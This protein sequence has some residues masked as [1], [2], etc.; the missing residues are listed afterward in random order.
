VT[1]IAEDK[2]YTPDDMAV[3]AQ[4]LTDQYLHKRYPKAPR[5]YVI[6]T[7]DK[8]IATAL[9]E[10]KEREEKG[11]STETTGGQDTSTAA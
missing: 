11:T 9:K 1:A 6:C 8:A 5:C 4:A 2:V 10:L 7:W 3:E